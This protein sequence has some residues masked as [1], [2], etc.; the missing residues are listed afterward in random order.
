MALFVLIHGAWEAGWVWRSVEDHLR[1]AGHEVFRPSLTGVGERSHL[2]T[3]AV[4]LEMHISDILGLIKWERLRNVT[5]VGHSYGGMVATGVADR[6]RDLIGSLVYLDAFLPKDGQSLFDLLPRERTAGMMKIVEEH[7]EGWYV[8]VE[9]MPGQQ[10]TEPS[11]AAL[12]K[13]LSVPQ[14]LATFSQKLHLSG[15]Y[16]E[17]EKKAYVIASGYSPSVFTP[18]ADEAREFGWP[19]D[20]LPTHHFVMLSMPRETATVLMRHAA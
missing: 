11:E 13:E 18:F 9:A 20:D 15:N 3:R 8:P 6:A 10:V 2:L 19:V 17:V 14:P 1:A 12:L 16:L 7:G 5:L 4:D